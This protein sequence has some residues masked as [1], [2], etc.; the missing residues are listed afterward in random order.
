MNATPQIEPGSEPD[1][2][3]CTDLL[4]LSD[5]RILAHNLTPTMAAMLTVINPQDEFLKSR[6]Q[7]PM[8]SGA[9]P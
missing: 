8:A 7:Q 2:H 3:S 9:Q 6:A 4:I 1:E 5:G